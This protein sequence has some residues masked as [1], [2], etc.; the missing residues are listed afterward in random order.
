MFSKI[1]SR[2]KDTAAWRLSIWTT[3]AFA[4]GS[5]IAFGIVY[6]MVSLGIRERSD[7]WLVGES[8]TLKEVSDATPRDNLYQRVIEETAQNA[9]HEIPGEH[10]TEDENRNSVFFLQIDNLGEPLWYGPENSRDRFVEAVRGLQ[11]GS[12]Q[13]LKIPE[14][15]VPYRVVVQDLKSG[16]TI[17]LGLSDIGAVELLHRLMRGFFI[18]W[19]GMV[20]LGLMISYLSARRT[21]L[22]VETITQTVSRIGSEDLSA[23]LA[24]AHNADE[25]ARLA[26]TFN[27]M[28][29]RI[30]ASVNQLRTVTGAVAHDM[31]SPVTSIRG[32]L[33]V[34]LLEGSAADWR[35][36]VA[37]AVEGLDRLS[38]FINT[39]LDLA[40]AEAGALPLRKEPVDFGALVEQFVDIYTPAF[41]ENHHQ[42]HVQ[43]H[44]PVTVD[45][46][47]SL[48][49][50]M[51][52]NLLDNEM[53]H[54]PPGCKIDIEVMAR[55]QQAELVIR[56]DGPGFPAELKAHAFE[57]FVK[58]KESKGH[59]LGLAFVDAVVQAHGGNVEIEDT[60]GGGATI[61]ILMPLVAVSVG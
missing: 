16:G 1:L 54:L 40:E 46:D 32:K 25:I 61:R 59:G 37:E 14:N 49:N 43:I 22:R 23:R 55:E 57:R 48:T 30:Q 15:V 4:A 52:S 58:G 47:V 53:A 29:D 6:Y 19:I 60:P 20:L 28:L 13:T 34:A 8:E 56:D 33:E 41:H 38:Q 27:R 5:A 21:L 50:R 35:E 31:K 10:E 3:I 42:V 11:P 39:T 44:E 7:Q 9:A 24:E 2:P 51:L 45:V 36:P 12:P 26:Q 18:V 17:Y